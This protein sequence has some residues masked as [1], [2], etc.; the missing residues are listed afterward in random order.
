VSADEIKNTPD[1]EAVAAPE[2]DAAKAFDKA[3]LAAF[4]R[5]VRARFEA[6]ATAKPGQPPGHEREYLRRHCGEVLRTIYLAQKNVAAYVAL[7][8]ETGLTAEDCHAVASML[9]TRR[10][11]DEA[12]AWVERAQPLPPPPPDIAGTLIPIV[13]P[14]SYNIR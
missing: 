7:T 9:V 1:V 10:K 13:V 2:K 8:T 6:A 14:L 3:G 4:E 11:P 12:L 5:Q